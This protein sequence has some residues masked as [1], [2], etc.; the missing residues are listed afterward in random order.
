VPDV[1]VPDACLSH[2][3]LVAQTPA[4][5]IDMLLITEYLR[6]DTL[7]GP[8]G[9]DCLVCAAMQRAPA[10]EH[11]HVTDLDVCPTLRTEPDD[12]IL[13]D[14]NHL[15]RYGSTQLGELLAPVFAA[16]L[17]LTVAPTSP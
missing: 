13:I 14:T 17:G 7:K 5:G 16:H 15:T 4:H 8:S 9:P 10:T 2:E 6:E 1:P 3:A 12:R 11:P